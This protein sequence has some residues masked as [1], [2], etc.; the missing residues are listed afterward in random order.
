MRWWEVIEPLWT[1]N[2]MEGIGLLDLTARDSLISPLRR[3]FLKLWF[4]VQTIK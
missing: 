2:Q 3:F 1:G 4:D